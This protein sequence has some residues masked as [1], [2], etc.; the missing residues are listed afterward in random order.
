MSRSCAPRLSVNV[1]KVA[2]L[3]NSR[4]GERAERARSG[5][6][7]ASP[8]AR[9]ASPCTRAP[10]HGTSRTQDVRD[11][12]RGA[13]AA[14]RS[15]RIQH[16]GRSAA[17]PARPGP[18]GQARPVTLV[19]VKPGEITS[20]AGW[21]PD[22]PAAELGTIVRRLQERRDPRQPVRRSGCRRRSRWAASMGA[23]RVELYTE[24][25]ARAYASGAEAG[26][27]SFERYVG[28]RQRGARARPRR[29]RR[30]R[31]RSGQPAAVPHAA[32]PRRGVDRPRARSAGR[33]SSASIGPSVTIWRRSDA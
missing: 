17:G 22:T 2:T 26:Q 7:S 27:R 6:R 19:P 13:G 32:A 1:N 11:D 29:Q 24:P 21:P 23:D 16:R 33:C 30:P 9:P 31:S 15:R 8:P 5:R 4:G 20:Q 12:R 3:R 14:A 28:C 18:R 10:T 25:F